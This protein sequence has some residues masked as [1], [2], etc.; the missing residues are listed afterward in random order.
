MSTAVGLTLFLNPFSEKSWNRQILHEF[1]LICLIQIH[2]YIV[3]LTSSIIYIVPLT[4]K[5][6]EAWEMVELEC[7]IISI[8]FFLLYIYNILRIIIFVL[9][10]TLL[11]VKADK[12]FFAY[13]NHLPNFYSCSIFA[14]ESYTRLS[15]FQPSFSFLSTSNYISDIHQQYLTETCSL[16]DSLG[17]AH[18]NNIL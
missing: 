3:Y 10:L 16:E 12:M 17:R 7:P 1:I 18:G 2:I 4:K 13:A 11:L 15:T 14:V 5:S 9:L 8:F 6:F